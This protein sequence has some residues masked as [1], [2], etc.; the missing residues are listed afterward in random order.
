[1]IASLSTPKDTFI[2]KENKEYKDNCI[3]LAPNVNRSK[4]DEGTFSICNFDNSRELRRFS[5]IGREVC[6]NGQ[7]R[8]YAGFPIGNKIQ[9]DRILWI[10]G[11]VNELITYSRNL[12][13]SQDIYVPV[14][15]KGNLQCKFIRYD[16][17]K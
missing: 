10:E 5:S 14:A 1:M 2:I 12:Y 11:E 9:P 13:N 17:Q 3:F 16:K 8:L 6:K 4:I 7:S 15:S